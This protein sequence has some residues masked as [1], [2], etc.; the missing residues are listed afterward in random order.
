M[1][2]IRRIGK[3]T[4]PGCNEVITML[5]EALSAIRAGK[6]K[7]TKALV[8]MLTEEA[9]GEPCYRTNWY[10]AGMKMSECIALAEVQKINFLEEMEYVNRSL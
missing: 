5:E 7:P 9:D 10:N 3:G 2:E 8:L 4:E 6:I 1:A